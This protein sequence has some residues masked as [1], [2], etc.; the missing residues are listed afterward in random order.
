MSLVDTSRVEA[1][2]DSLGSGKY[3]VLVCLA[4]GSSF[5][6]EALEMG[7]VSPLHTALGHA[8]NLSQG[9]RV[10]LAALTYAGSMGGMFISGPMADCF[11][12]KTGLLA[13]NVL[14]CVSSCLHCV[15]PLGAPHYTLLG[16]RLFGGLG[17]AIVLPT[18]YTLAA[19]ST[20]EKDRLTMIFAISF[21]GSAGYVLEAI[22]VHFFTPHFGEEDSDNWRG[23]CLF[24]GLPALVALPL[25][26]MLSESP[27]FLATNGRWDACAT[28]LQSMAAWNG[29]QESEEAP[30]PRP[31][32]CC[33]P[34]WRSSPVK[35]PSWR[36][37]AARFLPV[38]IVL[39][40]MDASKSFFTSGSAYLCKDLFELTRDE[41]SMSPT[42]LNI[43]ASIS[44]LIGLIIGERLVWAG[45]RLLMLVWSLIATA[46]LGVLAITRLRS[47]GWL[48]LVLVIFFKMT[49]GP[50]GTCQAMMKVQAFPTE[51]R[52]SAFAIICVAGR[53]L[54]ALGPMLLEALKPREDATSW[55]PEHLDIYIITLAATALL[56]GLLVLALPAMRTTKLRSLSS[57][58]LGSLDDEA[59]S[60]SPFGRSLSYGSVQSGAPP[61]KAMPK[62]GAAQ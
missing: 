16:L 39:T 58:D 31:G 32:S 4:V 8:Y 60:L 45:V 50:M 55:N 41:Q 62:G 14:I 40:L 19:E 57:T 49:Y 25:V 51:F 9:E 2:V 12:R 13:G 28:S 36:S 21:L 54:C 29:M 24:I 6:I 37:L 38:M 46:S 3:Q 53:L 33:R 18:G 22:G 56:S 27:T 30:Q 43:I 5:L 61:A 10:A 48:V 59:D 26:W 47:V 11:G 15:I 7:A 52:A 23:L 1:E 34:S 17:A 35:W 20:P 44:P 42:A